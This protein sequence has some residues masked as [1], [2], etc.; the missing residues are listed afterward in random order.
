V[1]DPGAS[2]PTLGVVFLPSFAPERLR[3][4]AQEADRSGLPELWLWEDCFKEGGLTAAAAALAW[5][6]R[7]RLG[8]GLI[9]VPL[10]NVAVSAMEIATIDRLFPGRLVMGVGHGVQEWMEQVGA[11]AESPM[12][13]L[14]EHTTA[15]RALLAGDLVT[16]SGRY[17]SLREVRLSWPSADPAPLLVG[18]VGPKTLALAGE[19]ADGAI[20]TGGTTVGQVRA[21]RDLVDAAAGAT[22][23][24]RPRIVVFLMAA[25]GPAAEQRLTRDLA[26]W[27]PDVELMGVAGD[28]EQVAATVRELAN[29]GA[30]S[31]ILQ[32]TLDEPDV[33]AFVRF[34]A[35]DLATVLGR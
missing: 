22:G 19:L 2:T 16:S 32:P 5:T 26:A 1:S 7:L 27:E 34:V 30:D 29:A 28:V 6:S 11:R 3:S 21:A 18:A 17:V 33:E 14:R 15:L 20:L 35:E 31:V 8:V 24:A 13:L 23:R 4:V 12:T 10:R 9:P 25:T